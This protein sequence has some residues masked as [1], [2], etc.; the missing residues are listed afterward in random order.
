MCKMY[1]ESLSFKRI[2]EEDCYLKWWTLLNFIWIIGI[3]A[4]KPRLV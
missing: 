4:R 1:F 3:V 2:G